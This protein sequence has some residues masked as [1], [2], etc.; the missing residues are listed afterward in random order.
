MENKKTTEQNYTNLLKIFATFMS[1]SSA[2]LCFIIFIYWKGYAD[3]LGI[4]TNSMDI[5]YK[6]NIYTILLASPNL[7]ILFVSSLFI[8]KLFSH[9]QINKE[10]IKKICLI[11]FIT[12]VLNMYI[13]HC[14]N[15]FQFNIR[16]IISLLIIYI[17]LL[18][19]G[20]LIIIS[21]PSTKNQKYSVIISLILLIVL[22]VSSVY[23]VG[24]ESI[25]NKI[26]YQI[27][28]NNKYVVV[29]TNKD[30]YIL[31]SVKIKDDKLIF[32][33]KTQMI[34]DCNNVEL[35][36]RKFQNVEVRNP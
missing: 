27:T 14:Y 19:I 25:K 17:L 30:K 4:N 20:V 26:A 24:Y 6:E 10:I 9:K 21:M 5:S 22:G 13:L 23:S 31:N 8:S 28:N 16:F 3:N 34:V 12:F 32:T 11:V 29:Y 1:I 35:T 18:L 36:K 15:S 7:I 33:N 2:I